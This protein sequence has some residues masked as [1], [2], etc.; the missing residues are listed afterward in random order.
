MEK[1]SGMQPVEKKNVIGVKVQENFPTGSRFFN[2]KCSVY[3]QLLTPRTQSSFLPDRFVKGY[4]SSLSSYFFFAS[5]KK[6]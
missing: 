1:V 2:T 4:S 6:K 3:L 5:P